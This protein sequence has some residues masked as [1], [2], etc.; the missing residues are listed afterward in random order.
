[1]YGD[2]GLA[3][4]LQGQDLPAGYGR[5]A[6]LKGLGRVTPAA[7]GVLLLFDEVNRTLPSLKIAGV[8]V[9]AR[10]LRHRAGLQEGEGGHAVFVHV[11]VVEAPGAVERVD[12]GPARLLVAHDPIQALLHVLRV[13]RRIEVIMA[14]GLECQERQTRVRHRAGR[15]GAGAT[16]IFFAASGGLGGKAIVAPMAVPGLVA[17]EPAQPLGHGPFRL[18][19]PAQLGYE[20]RSLRVG[21][22]HV[23]AGR[24]WKCGGRQGSRR[25]LGYG[26]GRFRLAVRGRHPIR[27]VGRFFR[28]VAL[29]RW[30]RVGLGCRLGT[31]VGDFRIGPRLGRVRRVPGEEPDGEHHGHERRGSET[32]Q[33]LLPYAWCVTIRSE[34]INSRAGRGNRAGYG[35]GNRHFHSAGWRQRVLR[36]RGRRRRRAPCHRSRRLDKNRRRGG[37]CCNGFRRWTIGQRFSRAA[38]GPGNGGGGGERKPGRGGATG[39]AGNG[40]PQP[41]WGQTA[42]SSGTVALQKGQHFMGMSLVFFASLPPFVIYTCR[43]WIRTGKSMAWRC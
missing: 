12:Q 32:P 14:A 35:R 17:G 16:V 6:R 34:A 41:G 3:G 31:A 39:P 21:A 30:R 11:V 9:R 22:E 24:G 42:T 43:A 25:G 20:Q 33:R 40:L 7:I 1:M 37:G 10:S 26:R 38:I 13:F 5:V 28:P 2:L 19:G 8:G 27:G 15:A 29:G 4:R 36:L 23:Q 18:H